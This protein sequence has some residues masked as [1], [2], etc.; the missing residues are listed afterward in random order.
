M[1]SS[2]SSSEGRFVA[3]L[4]VTFLVLVGSWEAVLRRHSG[5]TVDV[6]IDSPPMSPEARRG[7]EWLIFGNCLMLTGVSPKVLSSQLG[8]EHERVITNIAWHEQSPIAFFEYLRTAGHY[9]DVIVTNVSS[10]INGT[11]FEQEGDLVT[12]S[13]PLGIAKSAPASGGAAGAP[14]A[15]KPLDQQA[16]KQDGDLGGGRLQKATEAALSAWTGKHVRAVGHRYHLF[17][18]SLF[19][20]TLATRADL[21]VALYQLNMQSWFRVTGSATDGRG[22]LGLDVAYREDWSTGLERMAERSLQRLRLSHLLTD[23]YWT[24]LE[25]NVREFRKHGTR[26]IFVRMPEHPKIRA[27]NDETYQL[28]ERL[29]GLDERTGSTSLDLSRLGPAE[30]VHLFDGVHPDAAAADVITRELGTWLSHGGGGLR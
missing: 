28:N 10:W 25:E 6:K 3:A 1:H 21:D 23:R 16:Y 2:T 8:P 17:D 22:F 14:A 27:F 9:P 5:A 4:A 18:Y 11:N 24:L 12:K 26:V 7:E 19:L 30:G 13:D 15:A 20:G 29:H